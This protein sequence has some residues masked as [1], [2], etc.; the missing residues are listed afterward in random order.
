MCWYVRFKIDTFLISLEEIAEI[1]TLV[2]IK[3]DALMC[4][5]R[6]LR[7]MILNFNLDD[8]FPFGRYTLSLLR[9]FSQLFY[10]LSPE[11]DSKTIR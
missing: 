8:K 7:L 10:Y 4:S 3:R 2:L 1:F 5:I 11:A 9:N 6:L